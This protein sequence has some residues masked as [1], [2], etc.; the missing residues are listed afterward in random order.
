MKTIYKYLLEPNGVIKMPRGAE[1]LSVGE[2]HGWMCVWAL[3]D[4]E[5]PIE[6]R[7]F[8]TVGTGHEIDLRDDAGGQICMTLSK[9]YFIGTVHFSGPTPLVFHIFDLGVW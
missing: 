9:R 7:R 6:S 1:V 2:Q 8:A 5:A 4:T 3:V